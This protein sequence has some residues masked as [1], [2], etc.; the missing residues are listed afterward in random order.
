[1]NNV[2]EEVIQALRDGLEGI[3]A[4]LD[5]GLPENL[6][7]LSELTITVRH[8]RAG[9]FADDKLITTIGGVTGTS[10]NVEYYDEAWRKDDVKNTEGLLRSDI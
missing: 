2:R 8:R 7:R 5:E 9:I 1:M 4:H 3:A 6:D 10:L